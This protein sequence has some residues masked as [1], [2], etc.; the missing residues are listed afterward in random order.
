MEEN[1]K[2][3]IYTDND[4]L[5][6]IDVKLEEDTLWLTQAQMCE[7]YQTSKSNVSEHIKHI[8]EEGELQEDSV[9][10]KFRTTADDGKIYNVAYYNLDMIISVGYRVKSNRGVEFRKWANSVLKQY[11][12]QGYAIN[13]KRLEALQRTI[14]IQTKMLACTLE[15][16]EAEVLKAVSLY[17]NAL[18]L[19]DQYDHQSL[20][21]PT[22]SKA[23][24]RITYEDCRNMVN[25]MED[26]FH[27]DV[28]GIEKEKGKVEGILAAVYQNV[29]GGDVYPSLE[30]KAANL[31]YFMIKDHPYADGCKRIAASLFLEFLARNNILYKADQKRVSD[32]ALVAITLMIAESN[33][34]EK[35]I[36]VNLVMNLLIM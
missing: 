18:M 21:K 11:I 5:T 27:S 15:V 17:T 4:G 24:Y 16:D 9:V 36:M 34:K 14:N 8:F 29:F 1:N 23:I 13:E 7:L 10:R 33:P 35:D 6:K 20:K 30:E 3:L 31:L 19:L 26:S 25:A 22:G 32:G 28:F 2:I 12:I